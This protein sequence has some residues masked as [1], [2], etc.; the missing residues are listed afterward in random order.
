M[1][2]WLKFVLAAAGIVGILIIF[3]LVQE[4][5]RRLS[6][7]REIVRL[8]SDANKLEKNLI[9]MENLNQYFKT[10]DFAELM[11]REKLNYRAEGEKVVLIPEIEAVQDES[12]ETDQ[13]DERSI[14]KR[15]WDA[16]FT[17]PLA[18]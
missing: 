4:M 5:N 8:E 2:R 18:R 10:N 3:S 13:V 9:Q 7:Q 15:W 12:A 17:K 14:P 16:F 6:V 1:A 11:A